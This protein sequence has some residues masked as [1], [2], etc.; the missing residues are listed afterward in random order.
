MLGCLLGR[1]HAANEATVLWGY[2]DRLELYRERPSSV[3]T[4]LFKQQVY[5]ILLALAYLR[6]QIH[7]QG[8]GH[9]VTVSLHV[10]FT[11]PLRATLCNEALKYAESLQYDM[12]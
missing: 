3:L 11:V 7:E 9:Q 1:F 12:V 4:L 10:S 5:D 2:N 6:G 8:D